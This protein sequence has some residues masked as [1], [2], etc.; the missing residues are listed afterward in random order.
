M[1]EPLGRC[2]ICLDG[3]ADPRPIQGGCAC[4]GDAGWVHLQ[5]HIARAVHTDGGY[6]A[7]WTTCSLC[8][9]EYTGEMMLGLARELMRRLEVGCTRGGSS[10]V[11]VA[12]DWVVAAMAGAGTDS[13]PTPTADPFRHAPPPPFPCSPPSNPRF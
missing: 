13:S 10:V 9:Q 2:I 5:C 7:A 12:R 3:E 6:N 8:S 11:R 1:S 4:R